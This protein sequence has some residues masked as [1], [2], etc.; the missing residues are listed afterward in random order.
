M[1]NEHKKGHSARNGNAASPYEK[2]NKK[3]YE[4]TGDRRLANGDL[5]TK[6]NQETRNKYA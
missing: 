4:Y 6:A 3:P 1:K 2:Y 5:H